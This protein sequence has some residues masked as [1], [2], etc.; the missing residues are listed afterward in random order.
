[1]NSIFISLPWRNSLISFRSRST[2]EWASCSES[3]GASL[4]DLILY[5]QEGSSD[6]QQWLTSVRKTNWELSYSK[7]CRGW[8]NNDAYDML[9]VR[10]HSH[11]HVGWNKI[12]TSMLMFTNAIQNNMYHIVHELR[13]SILQYLCLA[14]NVINMCYIYIQEEW[15]M[16]HISRNNHFDQIDIIT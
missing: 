12:F 8:Q 10:K 14:N 9:H 16:P 13:H 1:M 2:D 15:G 4:S 11:I 6:P 3:V 5:E 7:M